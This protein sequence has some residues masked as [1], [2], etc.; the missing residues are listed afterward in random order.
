LKSENSDELA[1]ARHAHGIDL[2]EPGA[3]RL[4]IVLEDDAVGDVFAQGQL[5]RR[6]G[7]GECL[8]GEHVVGMRRFLDPVGIHRAQAAADIER[9]RERP[10]LVGVQH[11]ANAAASDRTNDVGA[12]DVA[13]RIARADFELE[14]GEAF[15]RAAISTEARPATWPRGPN[16]R[17]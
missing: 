8:V 4:Q 3:L 10:L 1:D 5:R 17:W 15:R 2:N 16:R 6:D 13:I 14:R 11:D 7:F 9:L 12:A